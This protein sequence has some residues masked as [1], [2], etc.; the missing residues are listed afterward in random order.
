MSSRKYFVFD[1]NALISAHLLEN[2]VSAAAYTKARSIGLLVRSELTLIEFASRFLRP[3]FDKYLSY[4]QRLNKIDEY[5]RITIPVL[6][7]RPVKASRD[8]DDDVFLELAVAANASAIITGDKDLLILHPFHDI[9]ILNAV[10]FLNR[11]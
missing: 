5:K 11:F 9:P 4:E 1:T 2:S 6:A 3:K 7:N 8:S 10:E